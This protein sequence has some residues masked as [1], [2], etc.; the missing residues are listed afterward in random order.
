MNNRERI[1]NTIL[2]RETDRAP[3]FFKLGFWN[4]TVERWAGEGIAEG[5]WDDGIHF[6]PGT[7]C[8]TD[9]DQP[10]SVNLGLSPWF[11]PEV[12]RED[13][14]TVL[15]RDRFGAVVECMNCCGR[16]SVWIDWNLSGIDGCGR[17]VGIFLPAAGVNP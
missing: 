3:F 15:M 13:D 14:R 9:L 8:I 17:T 4:E 7:R 6:D 10:G 1:I 16:I 12:I 5:H 2:G 11:P